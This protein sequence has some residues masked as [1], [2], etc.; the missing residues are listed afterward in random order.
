[1]YNEAIIIT[2]SSVVE[3]IDKVLEGANKYNFFPY[4]DFESYYE[5]VEAIAIALE[6]GYLPLIEGAVHQ[7]FSLMGFKNAS[8]DAKALF[9]KYII[10]L[11]DE[12][13]KRA[14]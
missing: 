11:C 13:K 1:M 6:T 12:K 4:G 10:G 9:R 8:R 14:C 3:T 7:F 5:D 2:R